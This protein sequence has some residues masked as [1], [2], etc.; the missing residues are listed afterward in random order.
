MRPSTPSSV[1]EASSQ[2]R[3]STH[4]VRSQRHRRRQAVTIPRA[5]EQSA[6][7]VEGPAVDGEEVE[8]TV[9]IRYLMYSWSTFKLFS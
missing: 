1:E 6:V 8:V 4:R 7:A 2:E 9:I 5:Q 3:P